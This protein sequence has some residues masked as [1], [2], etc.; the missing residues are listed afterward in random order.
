MHPDRTMKPGRPAALDS[1]P[2]SG[3]ESGIESGLASGSDSDLDS[4]PDSG[5]IAAPDPAPI[6]NTR[7]DYIGLLPEA[8]QVACSNWDDRPDGMLAELLVIHNISLPPQEFGGPWIEALFQNRLDPNAHPY[9]ANIAGVRLSSHLLIR[10]DGELIQ[11]VDLRKR[12]WHAGRSCFEGRN[13]CND[14]S[15][16]IELEGAD[17]IPFM[18]AQYRRLASVTIEIMRRFP[19]ITRERITGHS[20]IAPGRKT[21]PGPAFDWKQYLALLDQQMKTAGLPSAPADPCR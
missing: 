2:E 9:F 20:D 21:D 10:R 16:G 6:L 14:F 11:F 18:E 17:C 12:A 8:R 3:I 19:A 15:I 4:G 1:D 7:A 5:S 13:A